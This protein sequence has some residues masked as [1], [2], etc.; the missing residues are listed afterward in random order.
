MAPAPKGDKVSLT[1]HMARGSAWTVFGR[2]CDRLTGVVSTVILAR[3]LTPTDYGI[4]AIATLVVSLVEV[5][6][7][8][9]QGAAV[10]RHPNPTRE[11]YDLAWTVSLGTGFV[12]G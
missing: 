3:L 7:R 2:W 1:R 12:L 9:G 5:F 8:T 4:V 11:H 6:S 10:V